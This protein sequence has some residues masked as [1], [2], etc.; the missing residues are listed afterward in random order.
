MEG[1]A[2]VTYVT[3]AHVA[4]RAGTSVAV[5]SYVV[6]DGPRAVSPITKQRVLRAILDLGYVPNRSAQALA[7]SRSL[8][9]GFLLP[10]LSNPFFAS[11]ARAL[12]EET[13]KQ[14]LPL[15]LGDS[16][17]DEAREQG[18]LAAFLEQ[19]VDALIVVGVDE[20][21]RLE[22]AARHGIPVVMLDRVNE[23]PTHSS[24]CID[25]HAAART[26]TEVLLESGRRRLGFVG[27]PSG[28]GV[29]MQRLT[30]FQAALQAHGIAESKWTF[31]GLFT[32]PSGYAI[33]LQI[34]EMSDRPDA[35]F[36]S[37]DQQAIGLLAALA[38]QSINVPQDIAV[39]SLDGTEDGR[40]TVPALTS[41]Q[42][43]VDEIA[44]RTIEML[45]GPTGR[46]PQ[47]ITIP[48]HL[49][50]G[51]S[52]GSPREEKAYGGP[53]RHRTQHQPA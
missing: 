35:I 9:F 31:S 2:A 49:V 19:R 12:Q 15:L 43:P 41:V 34:G 20:S 32:K 37:S 28:L 21:P 11:L 8:T 29:S 46:A 1:G 39:V 38:D 13:M 33:G 3:R 42:Q 30:G 6:N 47:R 26:A 48:H 23:S 24:I 45:T 4:A 16:A 36:I 44:R 52:S 25:N 17:G 10:D 18:L 50:V 7:G 27:G 14:G 22:M 51:R 53:N 40:Y 5:V